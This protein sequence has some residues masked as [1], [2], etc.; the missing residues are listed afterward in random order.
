MFRSLS[1]AALASTAAL[2]LVA[3]PAQAG[4]LFHDRFH[5]AGS[6]V[7]DDFCGIDGVVLDFDVDGIVHAEGHGTAQLAYFMDNVHGWESF[8]NPETGG[9]YLHVFNSVIRDQTVTDN[10]DGTLTIVTMG[11]GGDRWYA[12]NGSLTLNDAGTIRFAVLVDN[13][14]TPADPNDDVFL[15][16]L[17]IVKPSTGTNDTEG[18]DFCEDFFIATS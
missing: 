9:S 10:G 11:A 18:R 12:S 2:V 16:D 5:D 7:F 4:Q 13:N 17:G 8:T 6:E 14:G 15:E 3:T 1:L